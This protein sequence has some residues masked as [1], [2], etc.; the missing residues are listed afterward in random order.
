MTLDGWLRT[1]VSYDGTARD[2]YR[3]GSG[4]G[5]VVIHE[6]PGITPAVAAFGQELVDAGFTV[7]MPS[8][9]GTPGRPPSGGY[10]LTSVLKMCVSRE[11]TTWATHRTSPV[12]VW[13]RQLAADLHRECGGPG[14]GAVGMCFSGGFALAM[15]TDDTTVAPVLSQPSLPL[16]PGKR[17]AADLGL[18]PADLAR[19]KERAASGCEV[20]GLRFLDDR[21]VGTRFKTLHDELR[22]AFIAVEFPGNKH[23]VLTEH[24]QQEGVD[25]VLAFLARRLR[26]AP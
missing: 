7:W 26:A 1:T 8:L 5:V 10:E 14:V 11:F 24:R 2:V 15:A 18:A 23:S 6:L 9:L 16:V 22:E 21:L 12:T 17:R 13:L 4:P 20:M 19:V 3:Q 25:R